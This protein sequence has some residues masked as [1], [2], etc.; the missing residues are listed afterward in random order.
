[1]A[2]WGCCL[3]AEF[4]YSSR[5]D[6][7]ICVHSQHTHSIRYMLLNSIATVGFKIAS[8]HEIGR[9]AAQFSDACI[10]CSISICARAEGGEFLLRKIS[11]NPPKKGG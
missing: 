4:T 11:H 3:E 6:W 9:L 5:F 1:M 10:A 8:R 2:C 7:V